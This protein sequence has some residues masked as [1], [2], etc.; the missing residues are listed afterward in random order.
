MFHK[1]PFILLHTVFRDTG[2]ADFVCH[3][4]HLNW[5]VSFEMQIC[6]QRE[7]LQGTYLVRQL[8][9]NVKLLFEL[10][11]QLEGD[12]LMTG[13]IYLH[14]GVHSLNSVHDEFTIS[15][16]R[17]LL[18]NTIDYHFVH[19]VYLHFNVQVYL[20]VAKIDLILYCCIIFRGALF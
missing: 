16:R 5:K 4:G 11:S 15:R 19:I 14:P 17:L 9:Y 2:F 12:N 7:R 10:L 18:L 1:V 8:I 13:H 20:L 6:C 3:S